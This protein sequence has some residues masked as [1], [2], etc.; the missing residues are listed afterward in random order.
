[1][2]TEFFLAM[3][4]FFLSQNSFLPFIA[5]L[6]AFYFIFSALI[7]Q[8]HTVQLL[9]TF[10]RSHDQLVFTDFQLVIIS[11]VIPTGSHTLS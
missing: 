8:S 10:L 1:M 2:F 9:F 6:S 7:K 3:I 11:N 4:W 5:F